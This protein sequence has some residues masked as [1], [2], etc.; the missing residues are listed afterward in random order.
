MSPWLISN[1]LFAR[2]WWSAGFFRG[3]NSDPPFLIYD[4]RRLTKPPKLAAIIQSYPVWAYCAHGR[5][6][7]CQEDPVSLPS[8][9]LEKTTRSSPHHVAQ[10]RSTESETT[11]PYAP[12]SS[13]F[14]SEP[15]SVEDDVDVW[16]Y[17]ILELHARNDD[18][19]PLKVLPPKGEKIRVEHSS[20]IMQNF[21]HTDSIIA[22]IFLP[23]QTK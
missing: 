20:A 11:P 14:G 15:P 16:C 17:A 21:T 22:E 4:V 1:L 5:Q 9:R 7:R 23:K 18:D 12:R 6:R 8:G 19:R 13:R 10:H 3:P 2:Y